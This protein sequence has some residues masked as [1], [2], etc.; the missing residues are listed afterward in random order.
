MNGPRKL[1]FTSF[2]LFV[3]VA[4][5]S[6]SD[7]YIAQNAAGSN[8]GADCADAYA[9]TW[10]NNSANWG[11]KTTQIGPGTTVHLCGTFNAPAGANNYLTFQGGGNSTNPVTLLFEDGAVLTAPYWSGPAISIDGY[12]YLTINGGANGTIQATANGTGLANRQ[13][14]GMGVWTSGSSNIQIENLTIS[15]LYVHTCTLPIGNCTDE[16]G[17]NTYGIEV[18]RGTN[19]Q[20]GPNNTVHD[21]KW[22]LFDA[23][24]NGGTNV[25]IFQN[26][27]YH[28]DHGVVFGDAEGGD[29]ATGPATATC[30]GANGNMIC[31]N[32][33]YDG[34]N[35]DDAG[36]QNH[37]DGVHT[38]AN[39]SGSSYY[40]I[41]EGNYVYG[42]WGADGGSLLYIESNERAIPIVNNV[43]SISNCPIAGTGML[44]V[45]TGSGTGGSGIQIMNNTLV[46]D[47]PNCT[48]TGI[49]IESTTNPALKNNIVSSTGTGVYIDPTGGVS[50]VVANYN[51]YYNIGAANSFYCP[52]HPGVSFSVWQGSC[53]Y[54]ANGTTGNPL[55]TGTYTLS[56]TG[57]AA[58]QTATNLTG[59][60]ITALNSD[61]AGASRPASSPPNWDIGAYYNSGNGDTPPA[62]PTGLA[63]QVQ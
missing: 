7:I 25:Q 58:W 23:Y 52:N 27:A 26:T 10:F 41:I 14:S 6:A 24:M 16:G 43:L 56:G 60:G 55:L 49:M 9:L 47:G 4:L 36:D 50:G 53:G 54:D 29:A 42:N 1:L 46:G 37:H 3:T 35:W 22:C 31:G 21:M 32:T 34:G 30:G 12:N 63:A 5:S 11:S 51:D 45:A 39:F 48:Q 15:N 40:T 59:L 8:N 2:L 38:W 61:K 19:V 57:S 28:C 33:I 17:Q 62:P 20:V 18:V 13:D 44:G